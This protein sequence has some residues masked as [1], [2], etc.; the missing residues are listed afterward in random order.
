MSRTICLIAA[1]EVRNI[2]P[3]SYIE[4]LWIEVPDDLNEIIID[5]PPN[6]REL[7]VVATG[8][9]E[10]NDDYRVAEVHEVRYSRYEVE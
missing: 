9:L 7:E 1:P 10:V 6:V 8:R 5:T 2:C 3:E 4:G